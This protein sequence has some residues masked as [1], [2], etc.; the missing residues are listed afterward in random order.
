L[1]GTTA[2]GGSAWT[3]I[4]L[5]LR[6]PVRGPFRLTVTRSESDLD[7]DDFIPLRVG[8]I[9]FRDGEKFTEPPTRVLGRRFVHAPIMTHTMAIVQQA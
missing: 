3:L 1:F 7:L 2:A 6:L 8:A 5:P 4:R 9:A